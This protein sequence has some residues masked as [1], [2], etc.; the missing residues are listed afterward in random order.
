MKDKVSLS[1]Y[2]STHCALMIIIVRWRFSKQCLFF[3]HYVH[4][5]SHGKYIFHL[6]LRF[7]TPFCGLCCTTFILCSTSAM[8]RTCLHTALLLLYYYWKHWAIYVFRHSSWKYWDMNF[9]FFLKITHK[10][11]RCPKMENKSN[12]HLKSTVWEITLRLYLVFIFN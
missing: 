2:L 3:Q 10:Q 9:V 1:M 6:K 8:C 4:S 5:K 11:G 12:R 7:Y